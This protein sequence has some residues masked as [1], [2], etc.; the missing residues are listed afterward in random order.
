MKGFKDFINEEVGLRNIKSIVKGYDKCE[1]Y[2]H[3]DLDGICSALAMKGYLKTYYGIETVDA[4]EIQYGGLEW[5]VKNTKPG[6]LSVL[7]DF[8]H[9]KPMFHIATDHHDSQVGGED[10]GSTYFKSARS[11]VETISG[12]ISHADQFTSNDIELI[13]T[14]DSAD[15]Y[16]KGLKP[17]DIQNSIFKLDKSS[18]GE[19]NRFIMG[20]VVNRLILAY[21]N[22]RITV[23]SMD[24]ERE[25]VN[26]II[27]ECM[28]LDCNP[29]LISMFTNI[30]HYVESAVIKGSRGVTK[31]ATAEEIADNLSNYIERMKE[32]RTGGK[33]GTHYDAKNKIIM[34]YGGG[35]MF[36]PGSYDRYVPFK[37]YPEASFI[38][39]VWPMGLVQVSCNPFK[40]KE[41]KDINLGSVSKEVMANH[42]RTLRRILVTLESVKREYEMSQDWKKMEKED[43]KDYGSIGFKFTDL[44]AFYGDCTGIY[45]GKWQKDDLQDPDL[46]D[47]MN[48][49]YQDLTWDQKEVLKSRAISV[50]ELMVRNSGGH[51][52][53]TN[54]TGFGFLKYN[55]MAAKT[56]Y[57]TE[58]YTDVMKM[59]AREFVEKLKEKVKDA[60]S[61]GKVEY[62]TKNVEF[63]GTDTNENFEFF[64]VK[65]G[66][67]VKVDSKKF[68]EAG[69]KNGLSGVKVDSDNKR[70]V[71]KFE[72]FKNK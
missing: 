44:K 48:T 3:K 1:I 67:E 18:T 8:A 35:T 72:N 23:R 10:S 45:N 70:I 40:E 2:F 53:I 21:K 27:L 19:K 57:N 5:A 37:N 64:L 58:S 66:L 60:E 22:K 32:Y 51:P 14:I 47:A 9:S 43:G 50:W 33:K 11:N 41:L 46:E 26:K 68:I 38:C 28:V 52:S 71:A 59:F 39:L 54:V 30:K 49:L 62:D 29:S 65:N 24:G 12:E 69:A 15:F 42:E 34:Q 36:D 56:A 63:S 25:H 13:K 31:L 16:A 17:D 7:V 61:G 6:N 4:H 20:L 55:K